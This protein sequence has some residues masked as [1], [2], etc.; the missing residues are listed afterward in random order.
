MNSNKRGFFEIENSQV[1]IDI[2][3]SIKDLKR[4]LALQKLQDLN[5]LLQCD[6][7]IQQKID[8]LIRTESA[9]DFR[10]RHQ[11]AQSSIKSLLLLYSNKD[12]FKFSHLSEVKKILLKIEKSLTEVTCL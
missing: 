9:S 11:D 5:N 7:I 2:Y 12:K 10:S 8:A 3:L 6:F 1:F 4:Q